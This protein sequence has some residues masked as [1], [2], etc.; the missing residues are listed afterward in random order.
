MP[1]WQWWRRLGR[2]TIRKESSSERAKCEREL[3]IR[4]LCST[5]RY[6]DRSESAEH[7]VQHRSR[8]HPFDSDWSYAAYGARPRK[9]YPRFSWG[10]YTSTRTQSLNDL[11]EDDDD[12]ER[13]PD[14]GIVGPTTANSGA[15]DVL[16]SLDED[17]CH[18]CRGITIESVNVGDDYAPT[19]LQALIESD[20]AVHGYDHSSPQELSG[21][22]ETCKLCGLLSYI[23]DYEHFSNQWTPDRYR[24][25]ISFESALLIRLN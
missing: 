10:I 8:D 23:C 7:F 5:D 11:I 14:T 6:L 4:E 21:S 2:K 20:N 12:S 13:A 24:I 19:S 15:E 9:W 18:R 1:A 16:L 17:I 25:F 22:A 3:T